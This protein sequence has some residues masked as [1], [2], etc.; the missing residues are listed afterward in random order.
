[1]SVTKELT[2][3]IDFH[4]RKKN[5]NGVHQLSD[6]WH[7]STYIILC[8]TE[9]RNSYRFGTRWGWVNYDNIYIFER[10]IPLN[11]EMFYF[12]LCVLD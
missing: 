12:D 6:N 1:M 9:E 4:S 2:D 11:V 8:S 5:T 3:P 10:T 7:S